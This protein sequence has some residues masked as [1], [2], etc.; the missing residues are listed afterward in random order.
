MRPL[1]LDSGEMDRLRQLRRTLHSRPE[2]AHREFKTA[3]TIKQYMKAYRPSQVVEHIGGTGLAF[4]FDGIESGPTLLF[5]A[6]LDALPITET[7]TFQHRST[8]PGTSHKCGHDGHMTMVAGLAH[9]LAAQPPQR[10][11]V[12]LLFQPA[13]E[14]GEGAARVLA[15]ENF[16]RLKPDYV[17]A[18]HN[19]PG[20]D[21][22]TV[23]T[24]YR[25]FAGS[26]RGMMITL[27][28]KTSHA[29]EPEN[30]ISPAPAA[31]DIIKRFNRLVDD[32]QDRLKQFSL[33]TIIYALI[34]EPAFG[35]SPG[36]G[37]V[38]ATLRAYEDDDLAFLSQQCVDTVKSIAQQE[39]LHYEIG[40]TEEFPAT[41]N[42][43]DCV[44]SVRKAADS[45][46][47][48]QLHV[49]NPFRWTEDF[50]HFTHAYKGVLF[51]LGAGKQSPQ[52]HNPDYDFPEELL[53]TGIS[54]FHHVI[55]DLLKGGH[56]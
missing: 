23:I 49:E 2:T 43:P 28:G 16:L 24:R 38:Y 12:V 39:N 54:I 3:E 35:T 9:L 22:H 42:D 17:F 47:L 45:L 25:H 19:L 6:E 33:I 36:L 1:K 26:S 29:G 31:A 56:S 52:L 21:L 48:P 10:G 7:N 53:Q 32:S 4:V 40:W 14:T 46:G 50:G 8:V 44:D 13:E 34:G 5:R 30:G 15:D 51:G 20:Y 18:L 37:K 55:R 11:R 27:K 41:V